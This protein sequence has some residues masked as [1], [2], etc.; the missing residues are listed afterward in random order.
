[1]IKKLSLFFPFYNEEKL[2]EKSIRTAFEVLPKLNL[3]EFE[4][5]AVNNASKDATGEILEKLKNEYDS[6]RVIHQDP[7]PGYGKALKGGF[8]NTR[9]PWIFFTDGDLQFDLN[10]LSKLLPQSNNADLII[11]YRIKRAEGGTRLVYQKLFGFIIQIVFSLK[12]SDVDCAFKLIKKEVIDTIPTL[13]S[14]GAM[15]S[16]ELLIKA[17]RAGFKI[18]EVPVYHFPDSAGGSTGGSLKVIWKAGKEL[19][20]LWH[21]LRQ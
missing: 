14:D 9:Y 3:E 10:E 20:A 13:Q 19:I 6:L 4:V 11:G 1:M 15:I 21:K 12:V 16:A 5:I 8:Y 7:P 18:V 2:V 17:K